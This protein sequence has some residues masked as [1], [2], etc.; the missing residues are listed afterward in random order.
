MVFKHDSS[1]RSRT[2]LITWEAVIPEISKTSP[3]ESFFPWILTCLSRR[4]SISSTGH[5]NNCFP[6]SSSQT[7]LGIDCKPEFQHHESMYYLSR[8]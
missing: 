3:P 8:S 2:L 7:C 6:L 4:V 1:V 5:C